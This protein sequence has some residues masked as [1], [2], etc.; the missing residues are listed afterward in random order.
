MVP[1]YDPDVIERFAARLER[2]AVA[3]RR[4]MTATG[5]VFGALVGSV[6][7]TPLHVAWPVPQLFG[8]ATLLAGAGAGALIGYVVGDGRAEINRLHAQT[9]L[10]ALHAQRT[11]LAIWRLLEHRG[12]PGAAP[13]PLAPVPVAA[14]PV[15]L[16]APEPPPEP[17]LEPEPA[18][19]F[20]PEPLPLVANGA[21][22]PAPAPVR[23]AVRL[24]SVPTSPR[25]RPAG[26][27]APPIQPPP[28][29]G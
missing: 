23:E 20:P 8:F 27:A 14:T 10:C 5:A 26:V 29:T 19:E 16:P 2:R 3:V 21:S 25:L 22:R 28:L 7:L 1:P 17:E 15:P 6:P 13:A 12:E 11:S 18:P 4:G 24:A 9:T